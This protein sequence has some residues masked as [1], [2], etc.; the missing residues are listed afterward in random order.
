MNGKNSLTYVLVLLHL[1]LV[2]ILYFKKYIGPLPL[3]IEII[4]IP[5]LVLSAAWEYKKGTIKLNDLSIKPFIITFSLF[6]IAAVISL[7]KAESY[8]PAIMEIGRFLSYV[9]LFLIVVKVQFTKEQYINFAKAFG[10]AALIVGLFGI[11]QYVFNF[12]LNKAGLYAL[13]EAKGRV[14]STLTN[15]NYYS[16]FVNFVIPI[17]LLL[18]VVYF[19]NKKTQLLFF[20]F[21]SIYVINLILT[22]TRAAWVTM[23]C[24][25][26]LIILI[27]PKKFLKN[28]FKPHILVAFALL[29]TVLYWMPDVQSRTN[30]AIYAIGKL[31][32]DTPGN[33]DKGGEDGDEAPEDDEETIEEPDDETTNRAVVSR[34]TLWKTGWVMF[35]DNPILGVG[36]G[37][38]YVRYKDF[39]EKYPELDIGHEA[40]S[41]HNSYLKVAAETGIIGI[42]SFLSF[43][44]VYFLYLARLYFKQNLIGQVIAA[45]VFV[46]SVTF[47]VQNLSN[48][49][50]FIPQLNIIFWLVGGLAIAFL[51][52]NKKQSL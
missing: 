51:H 8:T 43:Y 14:D 50:I 1:F 38:Y 29:L 33:P 52:Q 34:I 32:P 41:V 16:S 27:M 42:L 23:F 20:A 7:V 48:N 28:L 37:N 4:L 21:Y 39:V 30:S 3:S 24:A 45:G 5:I 9:F 11:L 36:M 46:G 49:L 31:L 15:P 35:K 25:F 18:A 17:L 13:E 26:I 22:Y 19:K 12:S 47:M 10:A 2:P 6:L 44:I 40:Y